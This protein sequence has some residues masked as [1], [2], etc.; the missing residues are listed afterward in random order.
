MHGKFE[1]VLL[2]MEYVI[3]IKYQVLVRLIGKRIKVFFSIVYYVN[4]KNQ[5]I[6]QLMTRNDIDLPTHFHLLFSPLIHF[7]I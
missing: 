3:Q 1:N 4:K 2:L 7:H 6:C 5:F